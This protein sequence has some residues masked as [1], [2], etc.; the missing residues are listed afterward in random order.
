MRGGSAVADDQHRS[1]KQERERVLQ[2]AGEEQQDRQL[3]D[4]E[5]QQP[6]RP[7]GLEPLRHAE[8]ECAARR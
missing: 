5:G 8:S 3:G 4:V 1:E 7:V 6:G 2:A